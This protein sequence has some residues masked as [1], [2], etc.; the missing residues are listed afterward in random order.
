MLTDAGAVTVMVDVAFFEVFDTEVAVSVTFAGF[1]TA[2]GA[3]Y[4]M[5]TPDALELADNVPQALPLQPV[6][7]S[8]HVTPRFLE[9]PRTVPVIFCVPMFACTFAVLGD[10]V[11][12]IRDWALASG[13][14]G[15]TQ[16]HKTTMTVDA[17]F[18]VGNRFG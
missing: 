2:P 4:V 14:P 13:A 12:V 18:R 15:D 5:A 1:G 16:N 7:V 8:A 6:P 17:N 11:T 10:T 3:W 9:S